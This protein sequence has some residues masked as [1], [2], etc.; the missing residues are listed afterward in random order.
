MKSNHSKMM[1]WNKK[2]SQIEHNSV[3]FCR[4]NAPECIFNLS[5]GVLDQNFVLSNQDGV[6]VG[7]SVLSREKNYLQPCNNG[8]WLGWEVCIN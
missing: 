4:K 1:L 2:N 3:L 7:A 5:F 8:Q 6:L